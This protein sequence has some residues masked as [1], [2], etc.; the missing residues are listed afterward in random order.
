[1]GNS[2]LEGRWALSYS[3]ISFTMLTNLVPYAQ[4]PGLV[5]NSKPG[6]KLRFDAEGFLWQQHTIWDPTSFLDSRKASPLQASPW[7]Q[8]GHRVY[9]GDLRGSDIT[10]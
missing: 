9:C 2:Q 1:M 6:G 7:G 4:D 8:I 5:P 10:Y 3:H